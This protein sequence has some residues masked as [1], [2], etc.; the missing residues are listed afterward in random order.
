MAE[1]GRRSRLVP[2]AWRLPGEATWRRS[3]DWVERAGGVGQDFGVA[4][5]LIGAVA[6]EHGAHLVARRGV[7]AAGPVQA[8]DVLPIVV[9]VFGMVSGR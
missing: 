2:L 8:G 7:R 9:I 5:L 4:D 1:R 3:D 6:A